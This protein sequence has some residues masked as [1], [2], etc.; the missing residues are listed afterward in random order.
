MDWTY[1]SDNEAIL[2]WVGPIVVIEG[3]CDV[4]IVIAQTM[5]GSLGE[6]ESVSSTVRMTGRPT[7]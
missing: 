6:I 1:L 5:C 4:Q 3:L 2:I 7:I